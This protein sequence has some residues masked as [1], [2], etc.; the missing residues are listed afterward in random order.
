MW[1]K[2]PEK[3][4]KLKWLDFCYSQGQDLIFTNIILKYKSSWHLLSI[5][6]TM[7]YV[8]NNKMI[9]KKD[10]LPQIGF[11]YSLIWKLKTDFIL[12]NFISDA[13]FYKHQWDICKIHCSLIQQPLNRFY[14]CH[15]WSFQHTG[16]VETFWEVLIHRSGDFK[17]CGGVG[18]LNHIIL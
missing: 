4:S 1:L 7:P 18:V 8:S 5:F 9:G 16:F 17:S 3:A 12:K 14:M 2:A 15:V 10:T 11:T 6:P 13:S